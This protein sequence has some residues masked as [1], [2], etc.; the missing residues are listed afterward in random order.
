MSSKIRTMSFDAIVIGGGGAGMRAALQL[1]ESGIKTACVTKVFPTRSHTVSAQGGI[2]CAIASADPND[3]WRWHMYDTVK[4]SDYIGDQDAIEYMC[5]VGPQAVFELEHMGLPF[6][7]TE[8]GRI[9]QRPFGGQSKG[10]NDPTQAARTCAAAD[11]T[12]H[13]LLHALYQ[14]NLKG[15]TTFLNEWYAV[16]LV[17][18]ANGQVAG[19]IAIDIESGET[20]YIKAKATVLATGG[21]GRIYQSTTNALINTGDGVGMAVRAGVP[22]Q[23]M[24]MWQFHPT[25]IAGAGTL[26]TE[27]CRGEGGYLI[28]KDGERFMERYAPNA[29]D[30]AGRDVVARSMVMEILEGRGCGEDGDHVFLKLDH[31]GEETL[32]AK[33][34][35]ILEL[36]RTF[37]HADPVKEPIPVVPTCH[38]MMGGVPTNIGGQALTVDAD[39]NDVV[40]EG[41]YAAG[42]I[43]CVS[44]HGANRLGGNSLLD[45]VVFGRAVGL[46][47]EQ[48]F[49][50][51]FDFVDPTEEDIERAMA[52]LNRLNTQTSGDSVAAVRADLQ[53]TMQLYF[54]VF[55]EG[56]SMEKGLEMLKEIG[57]RV[58]N[59]VLDDKSNAFNTARIE[60]LELDNL[61]ETAYATAVA[62]IERKESRGAH[63]RNDFTERDDENWLCHSLYFPETKTIGKRAVNFA[64]K[65]VEAFPPKVRTY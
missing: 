48:N 4:G 36:S 34:P 61:Y 60:A 28:N 3:D 65:T 46:Q 40:V 20:V 30:L 22:M 51:G 56:P 18:N 19:V 50:D 49:K 53:K 31:L 62:A 44:V 63:A 25:G 59:T 47:V 54:G 5:S 32:N 45:L 9:Y 14:G 12:G 58:K 17:K 16:D 35:G 2:T 8:E 43:A 26:V 10:P 33:L 42:E 29:K 39:G 52:R 7:R 57:E 64:P 21:A 6:S 38:Y 13:A 1:T 15:G 11:R 41:L 24:E 27:G 23:D 55:R 37:A